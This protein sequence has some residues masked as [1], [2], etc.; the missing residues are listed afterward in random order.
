MR[1]N[2]SAKEL[3]EHINLLN[4]TDKDKR[5]IAERVEQLRQ[6]RNRSQA[7]CAVVAFL[8]PYLTPYAVRLLLEQ[9]KESNYYTISDYEDDDDDE[10]QTPFSAALSISDIDNDCLVRVFR[11]DTAPDNRER[12]TYD[13]HGK[14][15]SYSSDA[16]YGCA[17]LDAAEGRIS[18]CIDCSCQFQKAYLGLPCRHSIAQ[19]KLVQATEYPITS[20]GGRWLKIKDDVVKTRCRGVC[21]SP[22]VAQ[23]TCCVLIFAWQDSCTASYASASR[24]S[25]V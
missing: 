7:H 19:C 10:W 5:L 6:E 24:S 11:R 9:E 1:P 15:T 25:Y 14:V 3:A 4:K 13:E 21:L 2:G 8:I 23:V 12:L 16:D 20:I 22:R 17:S 18:S